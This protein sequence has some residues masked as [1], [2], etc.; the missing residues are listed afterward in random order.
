MKTTL[1]AGLVLLNVILQTVANVA[2]KWSALSGKLRGLLA[3]QVVA[4]VSGFMG[5]LVLT[6]VM[7]FLPLSQ[8]LA[9]SWGLGFMATEVIGARLILHETITMLQWTGVL[10]ITGGVVLVSLGRAA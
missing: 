8:A 7:R 9:Y 6:Y 5:V 2:L 1:L 10:M 4:N 3:W